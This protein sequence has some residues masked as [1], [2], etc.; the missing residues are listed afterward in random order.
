LLATNSAQCDAQNTA[1]IAAGTTIV[2]VDDLGDGLFNF[3]GGSLEITMETTAGN[4]EINIIAGNGIALNGSTIRYNGSDIG[5]LSDLMTPFGIN[6]DFNTPEATTLAISAL[7][8]RI[9]YTGN[10]CD[11]T[12]GSPPYSV[13]I[14]FDDGGNTDGNSNMN[15]LDTTETVM[16]EPI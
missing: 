7:L 11:G 12:L 1:Q 4:D 13:T 5:T 6:I 16:L 3:N 14:S 15:S 9:E 10:G 2:D 8:Q